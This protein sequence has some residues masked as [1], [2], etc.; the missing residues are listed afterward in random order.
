MNASFEPRDKKDPWHGRQPR[1]ER[2]VRLA[3]NRFGLTTN[4]PSGEPVT[5]ELCGPAGRTGKRS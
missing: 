1:Y 2:I 5:V 4:L 3:P